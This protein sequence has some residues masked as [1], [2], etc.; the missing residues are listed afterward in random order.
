MWSSTCAAR[1]RSPESAGRE[2]QIGGPDVLSYGAMLDRMAVVMG[3]RPRPKLPVPFITPWLSALWLG[4]VTPVDTNV[5][6][7]LVEGLRT[8]TIV[9]DDSGAL[10]FGIEPTPFDETLRRALAEEAAPAD[11]GPE[12]ARECRRAGSRRGRLEGG[13]AVRVAL[14]LFTRDLRVRDQPAL[15]AAVREAER[16]LPAFVL[17]EALLGGG[18]GAPNRLAFLLE[19]LRDL[20]GSLRERG[21][22]L[23]VRR[24]EVVAQALGLA[25]ECGAEAIYMSGDVSAYARGRERRLTR[26]CER[27]RI[28]LRVCEGVT[29]VAAGEIAPVG[30]DH[31]RVFTPYWRAW[32]EVPRRGPLAAPRRISTPPGFGGGAGVPRLE[33]LTR[34]QRSPELIRGGEGEGS[35][36]LERWLRAGLGSY[37]QCHDDLSGEGTSRLSAYLHFGCLSPTAVLA[38]AEGRREGGA[39]AR[40]L[41]WRDFYHQVLAARPDLPRADYRPR[42]GRWSVSRRLAEAWREGMT[43]Y[44]I[45]DAGMGQLA[46]EGFM[47]NRARLITASFLTKLL[48]VD[49]RVGA[50]HFWGLLLDGDLANNVGNW[51]WV[52]GT[53]NDTRPNRVLNPLRQAQ[54]FD[55][56]GEYVRRYVP[57]LADVAGGAVHE[58]WRLGAARRRELD[59]PKPVIDYLAA[60]AEMRGR[61]ARGHS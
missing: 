25:R 45:V 58:P 27:E 56:E 59:Y 51:Q 57:A 4:L 13:T 52:A 42:A 29:V 48:G 37:E 10:P 5:A 36:R 40:Q 24:G 49:W 3:G 55:P 21:A 12:S 18:A 31:Y 46:R 35:R 23:A 19:S 11:G 38:R 30:G 33:E 1:R 50:A 22:R 41:C 28:E 14:V 47:H 54:R 2:V 61:R 32:S 20:D 7:P 60:A 17:D 53:G 15:A 6:R 8:E 34:G 26:A 39:F 16:V 43:G 44:P 9:T